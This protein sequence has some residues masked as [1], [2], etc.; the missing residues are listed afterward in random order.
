[1][2]ISDLLSLYL[3]GPAS[4]SHQ[5]YDNNAM[6]CQIRVEKQEII[7]D[8]NEIYSCSWII[9]QFHQ[10]YQMFHWYCRHCC[11]LWLL[12]CCAR[13]SS[14][15]WW[16]YWQLPASETRPPSALFC[17]ATHGP[18]LL[19]YNISFITSL[20]LASVSSLASVSASPPF[21]SSA[22]SLSGS[23]H[24]VTDTSD[25]AAVSSSDLHGLM[26]PGAGSTVTDLWNYFLAMLYSKAKLT[27]EGG[28][29]NTS[30]SARRS[31]LFFCSPE[32]IGALKYS[33]K[34]ND[35]HEY[36]L[37]EYSRVTLSTLLK[38]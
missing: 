37:L 19:L 13:S 12:L 3:C 7:A 30:E 38:G 5:E 35:T 36:L 33:E 8:V 27:P 23:R 26:A 11:W 15:P 4:S 25:L 24:S 22:L 16:T 17:V 28:A 21:A 18:P 14:R 10:R 2:H 1:M 20:R 32:I 9:K 29:R 6:Q 34:R 31:F